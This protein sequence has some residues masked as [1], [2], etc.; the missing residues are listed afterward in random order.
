[1]QEI[2]KVAILNG[3]ALGAAYASK[4]I[5][6][7]EF[8]TVLIAGGAVYGMDKLLYAISIGIDALRDKNR[9]TFTNPGK[10]IFGEAVNAELGQ[11]VRR[12]QMAFDQAGIA[13]ETPADMR[14]MMW[15]KFMI[16]VGV[17]QAAAVMRAPFG[18]F[19]SSTDA[20][21]LME[22]LMREVIE[23]A[24]ASEVNLS[25][26][27]LDDWY[28]ILKT[29]SADGKPSMLQDIEAGRKTEVEI[30]GG[31][32]V[33]LGERL[34]IP[35]PVNQIVLHTIRVLESAPA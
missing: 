24:R 20:Q 14:R 32:M 6:A 16:N 22:A 7:S 35:T 13:H 31:K 12:L 23:V 29:L 5:D 2:K 4:F 33:A 15:W 17:N 26:Q 11:N 28:G 27:D 34:G 25:A 30:F 1:M 21:F 3:G 10:I 9:V 8:E 19:Q 18:V